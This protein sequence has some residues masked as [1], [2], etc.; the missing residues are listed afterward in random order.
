MY[1][2]SHKVQ[3]KKKSYFNT[4]KLEIKKFKIMLLT[5][6]PLKKKNYFDMNLSKHV[7]NPHICQ[8]LEKLINFN[9]VFKY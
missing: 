7:N 3:A 6:P 1:L 4:E 5:I 2:Q 8:T 9:P